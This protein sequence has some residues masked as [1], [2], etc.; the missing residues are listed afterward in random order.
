MKMLQLHS[1]P[2]DRHIKDR[3]RRSTTESR[4]HLMFCQACRSLVGRSGIAAFSSSQ[5]EEPRT[6]SAWISLAFA[7]RS[8]ANY[9]RVCVAARPNRLRRTD[10]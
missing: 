9:L 5:R 3:S 4:K 2:D 7:S 6:D 1:D 10:P 8:L